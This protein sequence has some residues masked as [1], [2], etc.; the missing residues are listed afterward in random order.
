MLFST[1]LFFIGAKQ[2][3]NQTQ[4]KTEFDSSFRSST[5]AVTKREDHLRVKREAGRN[6]ETP[7]KQHIWK[8]MLLDLL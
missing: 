1:L 2:F 8:G 3:Y 6:A 5:F 7:D 4:T